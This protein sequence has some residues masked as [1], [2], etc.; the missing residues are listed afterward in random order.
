MM[1]KLIA[2]VMILFTVIAFGQYGSRDTQWSFDNN[3]KGSRSTADYY[4]IIWTFNLDSATN[5]ASTPFTIPDIGNMYETPATFYVKMTST[6]GVPIADVFLQVCKAGAVADTVTID[7]ICYQSITELDT[8]CRVDFNGHLGKTFRIF[9]RS[10]KADVN[11]FKL[12]ALIP[13]RKE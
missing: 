1:K 6:Y 10:L 5:Y 12:Y 8:I 3:L 2:L 7:T 13:K 4:E 9:A 11:I